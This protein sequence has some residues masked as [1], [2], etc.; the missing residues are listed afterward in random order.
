MN[1]QEKASSIL[2]ANGKM[3][4]NS[5]SGYRERNP[6][7]LSIFNANICTKNEKIWWGDM[8]V[9][10]DQNLIG[11][12]AYILNEDLYVLYEM[13]GRF[14]NEESPKI[15]NYAVK[16]FYD[17]GCELSKRLAES[18]DVHLRLKKEQNV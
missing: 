18:Y 2:G 4:S 16:F 10:K 1:K 5:K 3:I 14:E 13:D 12:L 17:G 8:D 7:N 6:E 11:D 15:G 9:T